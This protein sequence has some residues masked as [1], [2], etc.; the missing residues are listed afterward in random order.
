MLDACGVNNSF[1]VFA[2]GLTNVG[3][4]LT[5]TDTATGQSRP[6]T[7]P[8]GTAF[9]AVQDTGAFSTCSTPTVQVADVNG[10]WA[11]VASLNGY[12]YPVSLSLFQTGTT[13]RGTAS[14]F[15]GGGGSLTGTVRA[16]LAFTVNEVS[17]C[18]GSIWVLPP[19]IPQTST[20][21]EP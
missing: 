17:P 6:Y 14:V 12:G 8:V 10:A 11:A 13:I 1:W 3:V 4:T 20:L 21:L 5:V 7:N 19:S 9:V 15:N 2:S 18:T 16:E